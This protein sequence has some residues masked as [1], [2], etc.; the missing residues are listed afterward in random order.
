MRDRATHGS[1]PFVVPRTYQIFLSV[2]KLL[3]SGPLA[4]R[5]PS[6]PTTSMLD[7]SIVQYISHSRCF[8][9][10]KYLPTYGLQGGKSMVGA[11]GVGRS[12]PHL[13]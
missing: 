8:V 3:D 7:V 13:A 5:F 10:T 11:S 12:V 9:H 1:G 2:S 4:R 6:N